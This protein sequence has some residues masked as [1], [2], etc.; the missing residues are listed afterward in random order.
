M[1][2]EGGENVLIPSGGPTQKYYAHKIMAD[3]YSCKLMYKLK[4]TKYGGVNFVHGEN[5]S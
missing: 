4:E 1:I 2:P 3:R 5:K